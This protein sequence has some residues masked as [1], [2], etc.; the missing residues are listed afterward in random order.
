VRGD[1]DAEHAVY[2]VD[3]ILD[4][5][6]PPSAAFGR[7]TRTRSTAPPQLSTWADGSE[8]NP[9]RQRETAHNPE[10]AGSNLAP[11]VKK[12]RKQ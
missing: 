12:P 4:Y 8:R 1:V 7:A 5:R 10:V 6:S 9:S 3:A 2:A 11:A